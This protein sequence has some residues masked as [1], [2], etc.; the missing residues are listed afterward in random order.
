MPDRDHTNRTPAPII[1]H[2]RWWPLRWMFAVVYVVVWV[3]AIVDG[4]WDTRARQPASDGVRSFKAWMPPRALTGPLGAR[5]VDTGGIWLRLMRPWA[6]YRGW[7]EVSDELVRFEPNADQREVLRGGGCRRI[8]VT[9]CTADRYSL[10]RWWVYVETDDGGIG[11][12]V[13]DRADAEAFL[14]AMTLHSA[15][16]GEKV[17]TTEV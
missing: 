1:A 4:S 8:D 17:A 10:R 9:R 7:L 2:R 12:L 5:F 6:R 3:I 16:G 11:F 15:P 13:P 14:E